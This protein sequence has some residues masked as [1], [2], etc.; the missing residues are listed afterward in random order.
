M[1]EISIVTVS[2]GHDALTDPDD[3]ECAGAG[4]PEC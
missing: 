1:A 3:P 4:L 2:H